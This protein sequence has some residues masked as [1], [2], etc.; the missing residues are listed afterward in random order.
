MKSVG[1]HRCL[2]TIL[3]GNARD[4]GKSR[5]LGLRD[6]SVAQIVTRDPAD[7]TEPAQFG[8][9][10]ADRLSVGPVLVGFAQAT[11]LALGMGGLLRHG[12]MVPW[13]ALQWAG[14]ESE[15]GS[16]DGSP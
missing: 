6:A 1:R 15:I 7:L 12:D 11:A 3:C 5:R 10:L 8:N 14:Y 2:S 16:P 9:G 13:G 4:Q